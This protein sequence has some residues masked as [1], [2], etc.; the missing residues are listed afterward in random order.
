MAT[1]IEAPITERDGVYFIVGSRV[2]LDTVIDSFHE[3][4]SAEDIASHYPSLELVVVYEVI[5][6]YLRHRA[7]L[8]AYLERSK[9][10]SAALQA[11]TEARYDPVGIRTRLLERRHEVRR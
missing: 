11:R 2:T 9:A 8:N 5:A 10:E 1:L 6:Y 7:E 4:A 3:G